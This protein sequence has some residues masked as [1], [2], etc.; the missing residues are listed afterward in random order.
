MTS[1][2]AD[3]VI[4]IHLVSLSAC[5]CWNWAASVEPLIAVVDDCPPEIASATWSK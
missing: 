3:K 5:Q 2:Q 1:R 4:V